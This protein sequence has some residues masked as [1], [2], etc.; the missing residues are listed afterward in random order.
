MLHKV[1]YREEVNWVLWSDVMTAGK[2]NLLTHA[3]Y[4]YG[5]GDRDR[6]GH[7]LINHTD[8]KAKCC[9][10]KKLTFKGLSGR[11]L[12]EFMDWR[13]GCPRNKQK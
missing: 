9:N 5:G 12:S 2:P 10:L 13:L 8:T 7:E 6:S 3:V 4:Y 1:A 11:C